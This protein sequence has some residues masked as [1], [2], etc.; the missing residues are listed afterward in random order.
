M[1]SQAGPDHHPAKNPPKRWCYQQLPAL[2]GE[3]ESSQMNEIRKTY[4]TVL[5]MG[6]ATKASK[7]SGCCGSIKHRIETC[8]PQ[9]KPKKSGTNCLEKT[10]L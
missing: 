2:R 7:R 8:P 9:G 6:K 10:L 3:L 1:D 4:I 5:P